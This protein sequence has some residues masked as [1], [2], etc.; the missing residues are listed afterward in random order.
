MSDDA[1]YKGEYKT[2]GGKLVGVRFVLV[3]DTLREVEVHGDFFLYPEEALVSIAGALE[4]APAAL[5]A[6]ALAE[7]IARAIPDGTEWLGASPEA[8][9]TAVRRA[10]ENGPVYG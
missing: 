2:P 4:G 9:A 8:L 1:F 10:L 6:A 5:D 7:R 3:V